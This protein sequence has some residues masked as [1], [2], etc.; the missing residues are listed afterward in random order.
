V[1]GQEGAPAG[2]VREGRLMFEMAGLAVTGVNLALNLQKSF[3]D[4]LSWKEDDLQVEFEWLPAALKKGVLKG[5]EQD[6]EWTRITRLP[7]AEL[8]GTHA[9]VLA[10]NDKKKVRYRIVVGPCTDRLILTKKL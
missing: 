3:K 7:I 5:R 1:T 4:W 9:A 6:F 8:E 2:F 10:V